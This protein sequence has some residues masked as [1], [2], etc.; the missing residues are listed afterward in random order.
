MLSSFPL[1]VWGFL[2]V[3]MCFGPHCVILLLVVAA[4]PSTSLPPP[5]TQSRTPWAHH[6]H[7]YLHHG[8]RL[9]PSSKRSMTRTT[10]MTRMTRTT[11]T[12]RT[13]FHEPPIF[14]HEHPG[15]SG[16][17]HLLT[18]YDSHDDLPPRST[19]LTTLMTV[20]T[21]LP[22]G[23]RHSR[24]SRPLTTLTT[25]HDA[26]DRYDTHDAHDLHDLP[27]RRSMIW[28]CYFLF[29]AQV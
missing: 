26:Y 3:C 4:I 21:Y 18:E 2:L 9:S 11:C 24:R 20:T 28:I 22:G 7:E 27:P 25:A 29:T 23:A 17:D 16:N 12:T 19:T 1:V 8:A 6:R 13:T 10:R 14:G 5:D 15:R